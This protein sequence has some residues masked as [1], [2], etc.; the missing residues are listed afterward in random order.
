MKKFTKLMTA[1]LASILI[2][3]TFV[4]P[5][6]AAGILE[7]GVIGGESAFD[8]SWELSVDVSYNGTDIGVMVYGFDTAWVNE[9]YVWTKSYVGTSKAGLYRYGKDSSIN[10]GSE[11]GAKIFSKSEAQH[12]TNTVYNYAYFSAAGE[13]IT[14]SLPYASNVK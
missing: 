12:K 10:W 1:C 3:A 13:S 2:V 5:A 4:M 11:K 8:D 9:D 7:V 6:S 14:V